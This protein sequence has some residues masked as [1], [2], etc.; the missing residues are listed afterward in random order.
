MCLWGV[1]MRI[2]TKFTAL[3]FFGLTFF[4]S[5]LF[6]QTI[7]EVIVTATKKEESLQDLALAIEAFDSNAIEEQQITDMLDLTEAVPGLGV[8]KGIGSGSRYTAR[9][10][11]SFGTG[12]AVLT[13]FVVETNGL[14][15]GGGIGADMSYFDLERIEVL[16]GPQG[17]LRGRNATTGVINFITQRPTSEFEGYYDVQV[18]NYD[19]TKTSIVTNVPFGD[20][21]RSRLAVMQN[22][23][24]GYAVNLE[25]GNDFDDRNELGARLSIDFDVNDTTIIQFTHEYFKAD[26]NRPQEQY[27]HCKKDDFFGCSP[28]ELGEVGVVTDTRGHY[29]GAFNLFGLLYPL[30]SPISDTFANSKR[31]GGYDFT[32]LD[33]EPVH[34]NDV[35]NT[36]IDVIKEFDNLTLNIKANYQTV[37][38]R[39]MNDNDNTVATLPLSGALI[40]ATPLTPG[41]MADYTVCYGIDNASGKETFDIGFCESGNTDRNYDFSMAEYYD[42]NIDINLVSSFDGPVNFVVGAYQYLSRADNEYRTQSVGTSMVAKMNYHPYVSILPLLGLPDFSGFGGL[43]YYQALGVAAGAALA[44]NPAPVTNLFLGGGFEAPLEVSGSQND[45]HVTLDLQSFYGEL[46]VDLSDTTKLTLGARYNNDHVVSQNV[47][48]ISDSNMGDYDLRAA[49][50]NYRRWVD[51][52]PTNGQLPNTSFS[53]KIALQ[54]DF[55]NDVMGYMS[56]TTAEKSGGFNPTDTGIVDPY[57]PEVAETFDIG[58]KAIFADGAVRLN[59]NIFHDTREGFL[60]GYIENASARNFNI[61]GEI[62]GWEGVLN[63]YLNDTTR[64]DVTWL[65]AKSEIK[66]GALVDP[67]N[68][69]GSTMKISN[70][71]LASQYAAQI[72]GLNTSLT[73]LQGQLAQVNAGIAQYTAALQAADPVGYAT[74]VGTAAALTAGIAQTQAGIAQ[75]TQLETFAGLGM[76]TAALTDA[77]IV[78]KS[79]GFLCTGVALPLGGVPCTSPTVPIS[80]DGNRLPAAP[81][82]S[83]SI[84]INKVFPMSSGAISTRLSYKYTGS[85]MG[86][87]W[88]NARSYIGAN[89]YMDAVATYESNNNWYVG[90]YVKNLRDDRDI[91]YIRAGSNLQGGNNYVNVSEPRQFGI[92]FGSTF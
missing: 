22:K 64:L 50:G 4:T 69:N 3:A 63:A 79:A 61:D 15:T 2:L 34:K 49:Q 51:V 67:L 43:A 74:L 5:S 62:K 31:H 92:K 47:S 60:V 25:T 86:D 30:N 7:E 58:M 41:A 1:Y 12:A 59:T 52:T 9:G 28:Y 45:E 55:S 14:S 87:P 10:I 78:Y 88:N 81:E 17:T 73:G 89:S 19:H 77:G 6:S 20:K 54:H 8:A 18:G 70:V 84:A 76:L 29:Q 11:G 21:V 82:Q 40:G 66:G 68:I 85:I 42:Q 27:T 48:G 72:A 56:F 39:Q 16:K 24:E 26:D 75:L 71:D 35:N 37:Y 65:F 38:R 91:I 13:S 32:Y 53:Y 36:Q 33:R 83:Y 57:D 44:G 23:R 90:L 46:Y 80:I